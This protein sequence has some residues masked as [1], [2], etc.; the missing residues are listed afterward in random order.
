MFGCRRA[1]LFE[2]SASRYCP[3][4]F[5]SRSMLP[6]CTNLSTN[7]LTHTGM[8]I[9]VPLISSSTKLH[10]RGENRLILVVCLTLR[11]S[12]P[13]SNATRRELNGQEVWPLQ[14]INS[15][16]CPNERGPSS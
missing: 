14:R 3:A 7:F 2:S 10:Y 11:S 1:K 5:A 8:T 6:F 16:T 15:A 13:S 4:I 9:R 12:T